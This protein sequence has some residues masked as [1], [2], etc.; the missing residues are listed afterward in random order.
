MSLVVDCH[1]AGHSA[2]L[3]IA[4]DIGCRTAA[5]DD[6]IAIFKKSRHG[7]VEGQIEADR[8]GGVLRQVEPDRLERLEH[9]V[10][11]RTDRQVLEA[12]RAEHPTG[13]YGALLG[14]VLDAGEAVEDIAIGV[15]SKPEVDLHLPVLAHQREPGLFS[16]GAVGSANGSVSVDDLMIEVLVRCGQ[17]RNRG[18]HVV[19]RKSRNS[20]P[21]SMACMTPR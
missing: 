20:E 6:A 1:P 15:L 8:L 12:V 4:D 5:V 3:V 14:T 7:G 11:K 19:T 17:W 13:T 10:S 18:D 16:P 21:S 9:F 2:R